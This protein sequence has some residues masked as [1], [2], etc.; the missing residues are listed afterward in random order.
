MAV[1]NVQGSLPAAKTCCAAS[2][3]AIPKYPRPRF[4]GGVQQSKIR[5]AF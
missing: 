5:T 3:N 2:D 1:L 4:D